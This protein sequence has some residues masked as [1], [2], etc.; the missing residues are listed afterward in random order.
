MTKSNVTAGFRTQSVNGQVVNVPYNSTTKVQP[1]ISLAYEW[2][3]HKM[4]GKLKLYYFTFYGVLI[5]NKMKKDGAPN[6]FN[7]RAII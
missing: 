4:F 1:F 7:G 2:Y 3:V 5:L 6:L